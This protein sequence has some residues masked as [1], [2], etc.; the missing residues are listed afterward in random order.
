MKRWMIDIETLSTENDAAIVAIGIASICDTDFPNVRGLYI[1]PI[2]AI[3]HRSVDA[4][5]FWN[6]QEPSVK[7]KVLGGTDTPW[8]AIDWIDQFYKETRPDEIWAN[9]P[10]FDLTILRELAR[11]L[12]RKVPWHFTEER[13]FRTLKNLAKEKGIDYQSAYKGIVKHDPESDALCQLRAVE[14]ILGQ[15]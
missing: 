11:V 14:I 9:P 13:D 1:N 12:N 6:E 8:E 10:Q 15:L 3:G 7:N 4:I 2:L 5:T